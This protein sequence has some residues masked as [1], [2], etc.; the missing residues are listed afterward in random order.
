MLNINTFQRSL[1]QLCPDWRNRRYL[2]AVSGGADSMVLL[3]LCSNLELDLQVAHV[4]YGLRASESDLDQTLVEK[5]CKG[6][7]IVFHVYRVS[8]SDK[9]PANSIQKWARDLRYKFFNQILR[10]KDLDFLMTAH[11]LNDQLETFII[12]LS[13][14]SGLKGLRAIPPNE[15]KTLRPLLSFTKEEIYD[16]AGQNKIEY[17]EDLSNLKN[18]YL[19]NFIRNEI[20]PNLLK[21]NDQFLPNF[22]K[23]LQYI[24]ESHHFI[25][26]QIEEILNGISVKEDSHFSIVKNSF[27]EQSEFIKNEILRKFGFNSNTEIEKIFK[28]KTGKIFISATHEVLI[29]R[30]H[31]VF[32]E[33]FEKSVTTKEITLEIDENKTVLIPKEI[34]DELLKLSSCRWKIDE[35]KIQLPLKLRPAKEGDY[36]YPIGMIGKKKI[37]KFFKD[38]KI[39][40]LAQQKI[41]LLC[42]AAENVLGVLPMRQDRRFAAAQ[43]TAE[44]IKLNVE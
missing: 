24:S 28:A 26:N 7:N 9:K 31:F 25:E 33:I 21:V 22:A 39:P 36:F 12:N 13:K 2:L 6:K 29:D 34:C 42:D 1:A 17:R 5:F 4:N 23:S 19:R 30:E 38:E 35:N 27:L 10:E 3:N 41:W 37:P 16:F 32:S 15:N 40:I 11:H 18:D 43:F 14:A 20:T 44:I 8:E